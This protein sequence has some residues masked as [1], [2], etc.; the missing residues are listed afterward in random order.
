LA[1]EEIVSVEC[2]ALPAAAVEAWASPLL[3]AKRVSELA[4][5]SAGSPR[6]IEA[7]LADLLGAAPGARLE[8]DELGQAAL[9]ELSPAEREA[10]ALIHSQN[11]NVLAHSLGLSWRELD[12]LLERGLIER[13]GE[14]LRLAPRTRA[15]IL[16]GALSEA[17]LS[18]AHLLAAGW[19]ALQQPEQRGSTRAARVIHHL[20]LGRDV[21]R[22]EALFSSEVPALRA[23]PRQ[24]GR[25]LLPLV[26]A[27]RKAEVLLDLA[28][29]LYELLLPRAAVR[30]AARAARYGK[31]PAVRRRAALIASDALN[32]LGRPA[33]AE[34]LLGG[35]WA[36]GGQAVHGPDGAEV[37][38]RWRA[39]LSRSD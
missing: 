38:Q 22:A 23:G 32:R 31:E 26:D 36:A 10:V 29:I 24:V 4:R 28:E 5:Q 39:R 18:K 21:A 33:R 2:G 16:R 14:E 13:E 30:A 35:L 20:A 34:L 7:L 11:G 37:L 3:T 8:R 1:G 27:S 19:F 15:A 25:L 6:R 17:E 12:P 9:A